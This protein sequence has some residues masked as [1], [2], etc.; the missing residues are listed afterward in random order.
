MAFNLLPII[1]IEQKDLDTAIKSSSANGLVKT[2]KPYTKIRKQ[3]TVS[4]DKY[5]TK[6]EFDELKGLYDAVGTV[7]T[8]VFDHPTERDNLDNPVQYT[9]RFSEPIVYSQSGNM[10]SYYEINAFVLEEV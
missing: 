7:S 3:F 4:P 5:C 8:F 9:V 2:R 6:V 10:Y 1:K